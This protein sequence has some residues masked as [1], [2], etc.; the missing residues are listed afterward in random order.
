MV[1][2]YIKSFLVTT[3][4]PIRNFSKTKK[5]NYLQEIWAWDVLSVKKEA[6]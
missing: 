2:F 1:A 3:V 4:E 6:E 5:Y